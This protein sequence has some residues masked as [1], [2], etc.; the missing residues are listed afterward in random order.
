MT[1]I[2]DWHVEGEIVERDLKPLEV[3]EGYFEHL[4]SNVQEEK[5][6]LK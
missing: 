4:S 2:L 5:D 6:K 1:K 3:P